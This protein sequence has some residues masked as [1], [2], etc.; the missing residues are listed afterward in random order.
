MNRGQTLTALGFDFGTR[1]VGAAVGNSIT[2]AATPLAT[3][4]YVALNSLFQEIADLIAQWE[5]DV[6]VVGRPLTADGAPCEMTEASDRFA[7]RLAGRYGLP[8][9]RVNESF[10]SVAAASALLEAHEQSL[11]KGRRRPR[12]L[13]ESEDA[14]AA[15]IILRQYLSE[16][17]LRQVGTGINSDGDRVDKP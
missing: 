12:R 13:P 6:L 15:A 4:N 10:S 8:V 17:S 1:K 14:T 9:D 3:L 2:G 5:P 7:R 16:R 11:P